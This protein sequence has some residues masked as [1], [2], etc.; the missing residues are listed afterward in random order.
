MTDQ[1]KMFPPETNP[2]PEPPPPAPPAEYRGIRIDRNYA[3]RS[4]LTRATGFIKDYD[5]TLN[6]YS[7][8]AFGCQYCYAVA[9]VPET[10]P[11]KPYRRDNWGKWV[12][13][14]ANA[15]EQVRAAVHKGE[16]NGKSVY[17]SSVTDPYQPTERVTRQ[18]RQILREL[19][20]AQNLGLV[21]QT[22]GS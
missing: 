1:L 22:R 21:I 6:P 12:R 4:T 13:V 16:L 11:E 17:M 15:V 7:G 18:T 9:F 20:R 19:T 14:K 10:N 8:C 2:N 5:Y 3:N